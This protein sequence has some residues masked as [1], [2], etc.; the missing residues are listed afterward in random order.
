MSSTGNVPLWHHENP[1][2]IVKIEFQHSFSVSEWCDVIGSQLAGRYILPPRLAGG[3]YE[4]VFENEN[5]ALLEDIPAYAFHPIYTNMM[6]SLPMS[7]V[8][9]IQRLWIDCILA[10]GLVTV[11][12]VC[13]IGLPGCWSRTYGKC[14]RD[15]L[16]GRETKTV[17]KKR[18]CIE[19]INVRYKSTCVV[20]HKKL[21]RC[22][23]YVFK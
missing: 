23:E 21:Q 9:E 1:Q 13:R 19:F 14:E 18:E 6:G 22:L 7:V 5:P 8:G 10:N 17:T 3:I 16:L 4:R 11:V 15:H 20:Y 2:G 12:E